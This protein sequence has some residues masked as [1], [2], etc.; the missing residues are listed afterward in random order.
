MKVKSFLIRLLVLLVVFFV[1][2][3]L[4]GLWGPKVASYWRQYQYGLEVRQAEQV[5]KAIEEAYRNDRDGGKTPEET[6]DLFLVALKSGDI[7]RASKYY[8]LSVQPKALS[9]LQKELAQSGSLDKS[10]KYFTDVRGMG[11][12]KCNDTGDGCTFRY[13]SPAD[14]L[15]ELVDIIVNKNSGFWKIDY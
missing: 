14:N 4:L 12:K 3:T 9:S 5:K 11:V 7:L 6:F 8:E 13:I 2:V 10:I 1:V 15:S